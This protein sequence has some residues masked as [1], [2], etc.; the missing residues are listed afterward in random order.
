[1]RK[2]IFLWMILLV[3]LIRYEA[4]NQKGVTIPILMY[5]HIDEGVHSDMV[6]TEEK[7]YDDMATLKSA[8]YEAVFLNDIKAYLDDRGTLPQKPIVVTFD[9]G[10][11]SNYQYAYPI[12]KRLQMKMT[13]FPIG[14]CMGQTRH[15]S[16]EEATEMVESGW[17]EIG[18]HTYDM[19]SE[20][21]VSQGL[22]K[23]TGKGCLR[24]P[25]ETREDYHQRLTFDFNQMEAAMYAHLGEKSIFVAYP[26]GYYQRQTENFIK[27]R[28]LFSLTTRAGVRRIRTLNDLSELPR[29]TVTNTLSGEALIETI[30]NLPYR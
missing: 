27:D 12:A 10:Y 19:H 29:L 21:G 9:D 5:H 16:W 15:F 14:W 20:R 23:K 25:F 17:V 11:A 2:K 26:F 8:G 3:I 30:E 7:F 22:I 13:F 6:V 24:L 4:F 28:G 18:S 1:M